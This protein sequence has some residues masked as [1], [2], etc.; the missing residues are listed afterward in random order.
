MAD[1]QITSQQ[2]WLNQQDLSQVKTVERQIDCTDLTANQVV[3]KIESFGFSAN[4]ITYALLGNKMGY[5]GFFAAE[6]SWGIVP[7][8]GFATV[9]ASAAPGIEVGERLFGYLPMASHWL[10]E[11]GKLS[12]YGFFDVHPQRKSIAPVYD[13]YLRCA[14]DAGYDSNKEA[15]Q[16]NIRP[17]FM[18]SFVLD[19]YVGEQ[20][21]PTLERI[22]ITSASSKTAYGTAHLL[23][24]HRQARQ[25]NYQI[26]G[27]TSEANQGFTQ[28][29]GCYDQVI[30]YSQAG[31]LR[32]DQTTWLLDFAGNKNLLITLQQALGNKLEKTLFIGATDVDAQHNKPAGQL[33]GEMFFAPAQV[34]KRSHEWGQQ[35]FAQRYAQAWSSFAAL[36]ENKLEVAEYE[37]F[38]QVVSVYQ[39]ALAGRLSNWQIN[40]LR[41]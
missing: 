14:Q 34:K 33:T 40:L 11:A 27:L 36:I 24:K 31:E 19:D 38:E 23:H 25:L 32:T 3:L 18:T 7:V 9:V 15:L 37:G 41:F 39:Q 8:W 2:I 30:S 22:V 6:P 4:N 10:V 26:I 13:N 35:G 5:W 17:L 20:I 28:Q 12:A 29:L 1:K 16:M 21:N